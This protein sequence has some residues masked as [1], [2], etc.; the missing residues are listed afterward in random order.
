MSQFGCEL[1][2]LGLLGTNCPGINICHRYEIID[3]I[4][5]GAFTWET[6]CAQLWLGKNLL[7]MLVF[8][9]SKQAKELQLVI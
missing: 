5:S 1:V 3:S 9:S 8:W 4:H 6:R 7:H 2:A